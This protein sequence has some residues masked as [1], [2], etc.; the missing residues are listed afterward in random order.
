MST[1]TEVTIQVPNA[2]VAES[3]RAY[4]QMHWS[5]ASD[6]VE[7]QTA[8]GTWRKCDRVP[9][10]FRRAAVAP[11]GTIDP[12]AGYRLL[13]VGET[14]EASD[15]YLDD[16]W[17]WRTTATAGRSW[18]PDVYLP[19][20]RRVAPTPE[21]GFRLLGPDEVLQEGDQY[22]SPYDKDWAGTCSA[23]LQVSEAVATAPKGAAYAR[24]VAPAFTPGQTVE[25]LGGVPW[26][27]NGNGE[28]VRDF[29]RPLLCNGE[30][31]R[32]V[33]EDQGNAVLLDDGYTYPHSNLQ[34]VQAKWR[35]WA[36]DEAL[37][38][39]IKHTSKYATRLLLLN[40]VEDDGVYLDSTDL[41]GHYFQSFQNLLDNYEQLDGSPC[42]V[43]EGYEPCI[44]NPV[45]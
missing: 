18:D 15:E 13:A 7:Y 43:L 27:R 26:C 42:G 25:V 38:Q 41:Q 17:E 32:Q 45:S 39:R 22:Y 14:I 6:G 2:A 31:Y 37:G 28:W 33:T 1:P 8:Q 21:P 5:G 16:D 44:L 10:L 3:V 11:T 12:G 23:G 34:A 36:P 19:F 24:R 9:A 35:A 40:R 30:Q 4:A 29:S 20:R